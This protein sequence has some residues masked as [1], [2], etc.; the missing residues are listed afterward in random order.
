VVSII[1][2]PSHTSHPCFGASNV[3]LRADEENEFM[4]DII[5]SMLC[6]FML[7]QPF[8]NRIGSL[9]I[10]CIMDLSQSTIQSLVYKMKQKMFSNSCDPYSF[11]S[12]SAYDTAWLAMIP[13]PHQPSQPMFKNCLDWVLHNQKEDGSWGDS[14]AHGIPTIECLPATLA[15]I[16]TLKKWNVGTICI[17]KGTCCVQV[18]A[19]RAHIFGVF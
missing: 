10:L 15:C 9:L 17:E 16:V 3:N 6:L 5:N 11:I 7:T 2:L 12:P 1:M 14:D 8:L 19:Y 18:C 4:H 13:D